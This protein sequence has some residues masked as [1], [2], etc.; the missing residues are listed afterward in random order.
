[1][2][3][4]NNTR[5]KKLTGRIMRRIYVVY[6]LRAILNPLFLKGLIAFVFFWRSTA[7]ISYAH[8]IANAPTWSDVPRNVAFMRAAVSHADGAAILCLVMTFALVAWLATDFF[9][10]SRQQYFF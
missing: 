6:A 7:Y 10:K 8:V 2:S 5:A 3:E 9:H 4:K 1:M